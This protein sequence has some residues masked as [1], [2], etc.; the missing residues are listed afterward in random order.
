MVASD[1]I[2]IRG[3]GELGSAIG[4]LL[5]RLG[6]PI[7]MSEIHPPLAIRRPVTFSDALSDGTSEVEGVRA[8][9]IEFLQPSD[10][11]D[12]PDIIVSTDN[13]GQLRA[14][15]PKI[16]VDARMLKQDQIDM[17]GWAACTI[18]LG[19]GYDAG[20]NCHIAIETMRG[21]SL[22]RVIHT[23]PTQ[24]DTG[25]P[26]SIGGETSKRLVR[27]PESGFI[28]WKVSFGE[29]V[30][31]GDVLGTLDGG[32]DLRANIDGMIRGMI[33]PDTPVTTGMKVGDVDPRGAEVN[34]LE[35]S[36]KAR[37]IAHG[38]LEAILLFEMG[39]AS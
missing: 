30:K 25:I 34:H 11:I 38:V 2:W 19:P 21:H 20:R 6:Y 36:D 4:H 8:V 14:F 7:L 13:P 10:L 17:R 24:G 9:Y 3:A 37:S 31:A 35:I 26:G 22:G 32:A 39:S 23:G 29:L 1:L 27:A 28:K 15:G 16:L 18:G 33:S 12:T 5:N